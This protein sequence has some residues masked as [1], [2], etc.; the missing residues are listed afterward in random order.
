MT[1][2][3]RCR[4]NRAAVVEAAL[5]DRRSAD[6]A[7]PRPV[8][9]RPRRD[10]ERRP[11]R[12][13]GDPVPERRVLSWHRLGGPFHRPRRPVRPVALGGGRPAVPGDTGIGTARLGVRQ[14]LQV[15]RHQD[16][17][18][19]PR[20]DARLE[21]RPCRRVVGLRE[22]K[23]AGRVTPSVPEVT[24]SERRP[25]VVEILVAA[26][27]LVG[28]REGV[29]FDDKTQTAVAASVKTPRL[30]R[31]LVNCRTRKAVILLSHEKLLETGGSTR[32]AV[33]SCGIPF[34]FRGKNTVVPGDPAQQAR[35][36]VKV[37]GATGLLTV[38]IFVKAEAVTPP[39]AVGLGATP[40]VG[41]DKTI[42]TV[43]SP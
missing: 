35:Q 28:L 37:G 21:D 43:D 32:R 18:Q 33:S 29:A 5:R 39:M 9:L 36:Q 20:K 6:D 38:V 27:V 25:Q 19:V 34:V 8:A 3:G 4:G 17:G 26:P 14:R 42:A 16:V 24:L 12:R 2:R 40:V 11:R 22:G 30:R 23:V 15:R 13:P 7:S 1:L 31:P 10:T 41:A